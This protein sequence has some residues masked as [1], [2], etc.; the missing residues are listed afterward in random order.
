[1]IRRY[2]YSRITAIVIGKLREGEELYLDGLV[3]RGIGSQ[4]VLN[5]SIKGLTLAVSLGI[6]RS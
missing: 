1:M 2:A 4:V 6:I 5:D 3:F